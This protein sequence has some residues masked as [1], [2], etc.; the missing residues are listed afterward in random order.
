M[1]IPRGPKFTRVVGA[2]YKKD[3]FTCML[4]TNV[5]INAS[6]GTNVTFPLYSP[7]AVSG[8][9]FQGLSA[10]FG[11]ASSLF[12]NCRVLAVRIK[13]MTV[14]NLEA[15]FIIATA[16]LTLASPTTGSLNSLASQQPYQSG[17]NGAVWKSILGF[18]AGSTPASVGVSTSL[19]S[20]F[21]V[22]HVDGLADAYTNVWDSTTDSIVPATSGVSLV[23]L[24]AGL[25]ANL[26]TALGGQFFGEID[27]QCEF[28][29]VNPTKAA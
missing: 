5:T 21:H 4:N 15:K 22:G 23:L 18:G 25:N 1:S 13:T 9:V 7:T 20:D 17:R 29:G 10:Y 14:T 19:A 11:T 16:C 2:H 27:V 6:P 24:A 28:F 12:V 3:W 8:V 26:T